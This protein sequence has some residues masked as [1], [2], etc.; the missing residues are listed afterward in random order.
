MIRTI[1]HLLRKEFIQTFRDRRMLMPIFVAPVIQLI[2]FGYGVNMDINHI[3]LAVLDYD[4]TQESRSLIAAFIPTE[5]FRLKGELSSSREIDRLLEARKI[6]AAL[7][8]PEHF[9]RDLKDRKETAVQVI[10]DG[11]DA[12][13]ATIIQNYVSLI[14]AN[15]S[16]G[17]L[18]EVLG[19]KPEGLVIP[20][21]RIWFNPELRSSVYFVPGIICLILML[22]TLTLT[23]M[24]ITREREMGT[25]EQLIV[26]PI[27]V[28]ELVLGK[29]IPF[30][31]IGFFDVIL[32]LT[33]G[34]LIFS[35]P[36]LGSLP[37]LF[38][39]CFLFVLTTLNLGLLISTISRTQQQAMMT[40]FFFMMPAM[41]LSGIFTSIE[42][43]PKP[44]QYITYLNPLRYF[45]KAVRAILLKGNGIS[46]LWPEVLALFGMGLIAMTISS[47][48]FR[49]YL[50]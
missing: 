4:H 34:K 38:G 44:I 18:T 36:I 50:E 15:Y 35:V 19:R 23:S 42:S 27:R 31:I 8:I 49:K 14:A 5:Y 16:A 26:S 46:V 17:I 7:V 1:L 47:L 13:S 28:L 21:P 9:G 37:F 10:I 45:S 6:Q 43:M 48:R 29:T 39:V 24:A 12:N 3:P 33:A 41:L 22:T 32:V 25:L 11:T 40:A 30:V 20:E 2:L